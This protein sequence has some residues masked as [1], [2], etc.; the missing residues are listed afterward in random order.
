MEERIKAL[1]KALGLTQQEFADRLSIKRNTIANYE[2]GRNAPIDAVISLICRSCNV[3]ETWLRTG[4]GEMLAETDDSLFAAFAR[5]NNLS[6]EEQ[7]AARFFLRLTPAERRAALDYVRALA[8]ELEK[9]EPQNVPPRML[10]DVPEKP[11]G[12]SDDEWAMVQQSRTA[13]DLPSEAVG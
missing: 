6:T 5:E 11:P 10:P 7:A 8:A 13:K 1:R 4:E 9:A 2:T 3:N 12:L